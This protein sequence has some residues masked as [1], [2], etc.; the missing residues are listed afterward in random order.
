[1]PRQLKHENDRSCNI[2]NKE[3]RRH[4]QK[5]YKQ[6]LRHQHYKNRDVWN[7]EKKSK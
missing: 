4:K 2:S 6:M 7:C 5:G 3:L 1:M